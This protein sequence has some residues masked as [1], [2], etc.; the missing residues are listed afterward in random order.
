MADQTSIARIVI[1]SRPITRKF[2]KK[3]KKRYFVRLLVFQLNRLLFD[4]FPVPLNIPE[5][6]VLDPGKLLACFMIDL[7]VSFCLV[8]KVRMFFK[9]T[10]PFISSL[11]E[12]E[13][14]ARATAP[15]I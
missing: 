2:I 7:F 8:K 11:E 15:F 13:I 10:H 3:F 14:T 6:H 12:T 5:C 4:L 1:R 9:E